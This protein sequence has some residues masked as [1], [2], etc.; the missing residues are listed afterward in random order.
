MDQDVPPAQRDEATHRAH[1]TA[2]NAGADMV[3]VHDAAGAF[4]S[5]LSS[6]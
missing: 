6:P 2:V 3:R 1:L 4:R 5:L